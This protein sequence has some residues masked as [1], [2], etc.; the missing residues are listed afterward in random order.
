MD[1][2]FKVG[3]RVRIRSWDDMAK[4]YGLDWEGDIGTSY[5]CFVKEM[6]NMCGVEATIS[7]IY[8]DEEVILDQFDKYKDEGRRWKYSISM[9]EKV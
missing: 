5:Y 7:K 1:R 4:E 3:D 8:D 2:D 9:I 6:R